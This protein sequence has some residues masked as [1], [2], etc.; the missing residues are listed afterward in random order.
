[1]G[2]IKIYGCIPMV[3]ALEEDYPMDEI[4]LFD[5]YEETSFI[6]SPVSETI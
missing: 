4:V 2:R 1:M 6:W 5:W 3:K